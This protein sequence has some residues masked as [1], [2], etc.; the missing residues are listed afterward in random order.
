MN[1][2]VLLSSDV[3]WKLKL[4]EGNMIDWQERK[5]WQIEMQSRWQVS[6]KKFEVMVYVAVSDS[7]EGITKNQRHAAT[8]SCRPTEMLL[9]KCTLTWTREQETRESEEKM[10]IERRK[11]L[12]SFESVKR[13]LRWRRER[14][15]HRKG[16]KSWMDVTT[17]GNIRFLLSSRERESLSKLNIRQKRNT[18]P[19]LLQFAFMHKLFFDC[20]ISYRSELFNN[21]FC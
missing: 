3:D 15:I 1:Q 14:K 17:K 19:C 20:Y 7:R 12:E 4:K 9:R 11:R 13:Y 18:F 5:W 21:L 2:Q 16:K 6:S 10:S 8:C